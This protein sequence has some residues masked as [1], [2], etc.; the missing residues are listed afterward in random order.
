MHELLVNAWSGWL[1]YTDNGKFAALL[2]VVLL[3]LWFRRGRRNKELLI[4]TT[5]AAV[6]CIFPVSAALLQKYQTLFYDYEWIWSYVPVIIMLAYGITVFLTSRW[7]NYQKEVRQKGNSV[8]RKLFWENIAVTA[9]VV[10]VVLLCGRLGN[11]VFQAEE[12]ALERQQALLVLEALLESEELAPDALT[13]QVELEQLASNALTQQAESE[14]LAPD[15]LTQQVESEQLVL[16]APQEV[17]AYARAYDGNIRL[18]YGRNMWDKALMGYSY[19]SYGDVEESLYQWMSSVEEDGDQSSEK[20]LA[21]GLPCVEAALERGVNC[22]LLPGSTS[23]ENVEALEDVL[24]E[25][26][27]LM[28]GYYIFWLMDK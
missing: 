1:R 10:A 19:E 13:Q 2:L 9:G 4:Y 11:P 12:E 14:E 28:E 6:L 26:A 17:M 18:I 5:I 15:A 27:E 21:G 23:V 16:W 3:F 24:K 22:I 7:E 25:K 20:F 8:T